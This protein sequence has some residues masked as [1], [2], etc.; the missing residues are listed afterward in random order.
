MTGRRWPQHR[1]LWC[2]KGSGM[3]VRGFHES[4][5]REAAATSGVR[6]P[7]SVGE[8]AAR[9]NLD[10]SHVSQLIAHAFRKYLILVAGHRVCGTC[11]AWCFIGKARTRRCGSCSGRGYFTD[12]RPISAGISHPEIPRNP[13][14]RWRISPKCPKPSKRSGSQVAAAGRRSGPSKV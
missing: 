3:I 12:E 2:H 14:P 7:I 11:D 1:C 13:T 8:I 5:A 4:C 6:G 10:P 9:W